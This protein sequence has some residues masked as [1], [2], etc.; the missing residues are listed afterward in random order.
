[1]ENVT[2][3]GWFEWDA[4]I[5]GDG[6]LS[7]RPSGCYSDGTLNLDVF[8]CFASSLLRS[9]SLFL[10]GFDCNLSRLIWLFGTFS[11]AFLNPCSPRD[12]D[13]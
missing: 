2:L 11:R 1:M 3:L 5:P 13:P 10:P 9:L 7:N 4:E 8:Y 6:V 12:L